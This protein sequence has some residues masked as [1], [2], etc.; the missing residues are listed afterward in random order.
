MGPKKSV[1]DHVLVRASCQPDCTAVLPAAPISMA[2]LHL[3]SR[4]H[5]V[6]LIAGSHRLPPTL[7]TRFNS[8]VRHPLLAA[9]GNENQ[10]VVICR[11]IQLDRNLT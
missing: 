2:A 9:A 10:A 8:E 3:H 5:L 11:L 6:L 4:L 7:S 1:C